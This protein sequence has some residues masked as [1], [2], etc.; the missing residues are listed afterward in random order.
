M[1]L[2]SSF[3]AEEREFRGQVLSGTFLWKYFLILYINS[4]FK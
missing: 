3:S 4:M 1:I 2:L